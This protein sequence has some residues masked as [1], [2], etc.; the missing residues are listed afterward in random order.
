[1]HSI[2][3]ENDERYTSTFGA[4]STQGYN[5]VDKFDLDATKGNLCCQKI[6]VTGV[7][8]ISIDI[9]ET[10]WRTKEFEEPAHSVDTVSDNHSVMRHGVTGY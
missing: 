2:P 8:T 5:A 4:F 7:E 6:H 1:M 10:R 3:K 9:V